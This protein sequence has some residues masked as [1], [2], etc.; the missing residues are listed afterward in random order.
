MQD[1]N[2]MLF[3]EKDFSKSGTD[4]YNSLLKLE[5]RIQDIFTP[6]LVHDRDYIYRIENACL[7]GDSYIDTMDNPICPKSFDTALLR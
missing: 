5:P 6:E 2:G 3:T 7:S 4:I 1:Q